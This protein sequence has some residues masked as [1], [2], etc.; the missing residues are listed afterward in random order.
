MTPITWG[1]KHRGPLTDQMKRELA[2]IAFLE[3]EDFPELEKGNFDTC[4]TK[5]GASITTPSGR[6]FDWRWNLK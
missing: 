5:H 1:P 3:P 4:R 6:V 2:N